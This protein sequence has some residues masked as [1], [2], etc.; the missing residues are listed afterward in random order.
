MI[1]SKKNKYI[2]I[3]HP[4]SGGTAIMNELIE[5]YDGKTLYHKHCNYPALINNSDIKNLSDYYVFGV[6][7]DPIDKAFSEYCKIKYNSRNQYTNKDLFIENGGN[8]SKKMR[9]VYQDIKKLHSFEE[10]LRYRYSI[11]L[12]HDWVTINAPYLNGIIR[13]NNLSHDFKSTLK[14]LK[15]EIKRD[16]PYINK[17]NKKDSEMKIDEKLKHKI[18]GPYYNFNNHLFNIKYQK[19]VPF[20]SSM[21]YNILVFL[22]K[23]IV[24]KKDQKFINEKRG[25][26]HK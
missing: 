8:V 2:F 23:L 3:G 1:I 11:K 6:V 25:L 20:F 19:K 13:F 24:S 7:R 15:I 21:Y 17:T 18:F 26:N 16:L 14:H 9:E 10:Y 5:N 12:Y 4:S 22:H